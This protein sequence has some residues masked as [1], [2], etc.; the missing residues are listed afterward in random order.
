MLYQVLMQLL[1]VRFYVTLCRRIL[2]AG[3]RDGGPGRRVCQALTWYER[4][5]GFMIGHLEVCYVNPETMVENY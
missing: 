3:G 4:A 5:G 1:A 2:G